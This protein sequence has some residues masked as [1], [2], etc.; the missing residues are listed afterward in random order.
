MDNI[1][2]YSK[3]RRGSVKRV[4]NITRDWQ[5]Q[6][7]PLKDLKQDLSIDSA[8]HSFMMEN[9]EF[10]AQFRNFQDSTDDYQTIML[11]TTLTLTE[12]QDLEDELDCDEWEDLLAKCKDTLGGDADHFFRE[13]SSDSVSMMEMEENTEKESTT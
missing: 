3:P 2:L 9:G 13:S 12:V 8:V 7:L 10:L 1:K 6:N 4:Q 5:L 11:A